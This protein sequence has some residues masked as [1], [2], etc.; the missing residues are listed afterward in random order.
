VTEFSNGELVIEAIGELIDGA[1]AEER[2]REAKRGE[3]SFFMVDVGGA[4][5]ASR[6]GDGFPHPGSERLVIDATTDGNKARFIN[7]S[8]QPSCSLEKWKVHGEERCI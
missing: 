3:D 6:V 7:H 1:E 5:S 2:L 4:A 8:C